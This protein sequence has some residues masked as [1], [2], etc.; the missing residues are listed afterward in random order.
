VKKEMKNKIFSLLIICLLM[1][2]TFTTISCKKNQNKV[3]QFPEIV[4]NLNSYKLNG[5][6][7]TNFPSG[8]KISNVTVYYKKPDMYKVEL[9]LPNSL[10]KQIILKNQDGV[11]VLI[12]SL[13]KQ[14]KV[15]SNWPLTS[16]YSYLLQSLSKDILSDD[17]KEILMD[18]KE[19]KYKLKAKLFD[20]AENTYQTITFNNETGLP[21]EVCIYKLD[22][23]LIS[24][25]KINSIEIDV[26]FNNDLF[27]CNKTMQTIKETMD[28]QIEFDRTMTY[29]TYCPIGI[30]LKDEVTS[31]SGDNKRTLLTYSGTSFITILETFVA[32]YES[33]KTEYIDGEVCVIGGIV[34][35]MN[36]ESIKFYDS[37]IEYIIA[38]SNTDRLELVYIGDSLRMNN[39]EK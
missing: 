9:V 35:I 27:E 4:N 1:A 6:L 13:N 37:G 17:T 18:E 15:S 16:S 5:T 31:G 14:F 11:H 26:D 19:T 36:N 12:P 34:W 10:E 21:T 24:H 22:N 33:L 3:E 8:S 28:Q 29:P 2:L 39:S 25:F 20:N 32:P 30:M 7:E 38:S 23:T